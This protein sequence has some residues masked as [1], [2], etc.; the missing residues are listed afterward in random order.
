MPPLSRPTVVEPLPDFRLVAANVQPPIAPLVAV[1]APAAVTRNT[2]DARLACVLPAQKTISPPAAA[3]LIP[4][5]VLLVPAVMLA[6]FAAPLVNVMLV[7]LSVV[8]AIVQPPTVPLVAVSTPAA[9]TLNGALP[10]VALPA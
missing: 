8:A 3:L 5:A 7:A 6:V 9:V 1:R 10:G 2:A 4:P